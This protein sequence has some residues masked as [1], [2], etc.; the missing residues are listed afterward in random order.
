MSERIARLRIELQEL[1]PKIWRRID[2]PLSTTLEALHEAIQVTMGWTFSLS[3]PFIP[4][5]LP[6]TARLSGTDIILSQWIL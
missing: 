3:L 1:E 4:S 6:T 2:M 5:C